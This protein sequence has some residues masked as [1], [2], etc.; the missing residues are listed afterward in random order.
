MWHTMHSEK[1]KTEEVEE[2]GIAPGDLLGNLVRRTDNDFQGI[3]DP[4]LIGQDIGDDEDEEDAEK[5]K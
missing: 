5:D 2:G 3:K 1:R 4:S